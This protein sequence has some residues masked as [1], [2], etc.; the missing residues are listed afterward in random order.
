MTLYCRYCDLELTP[1]GSGP[2]LAGDPHRS[3]RR[4]FWR[5]F[6]RAAEVLSSFVEAPSETRPDGLERR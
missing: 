6:R 2:H 3:T 1:K 5:G 4:A